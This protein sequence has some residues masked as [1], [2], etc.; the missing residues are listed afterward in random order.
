MN[1][2]LQELKSM[3]LRQKDL[4]ERY[5]EN[6]GLQVQLKSKTDEIKVSI[7]NFL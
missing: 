7:F 1:K 3:T 5:M 6:A 4:E 2:L